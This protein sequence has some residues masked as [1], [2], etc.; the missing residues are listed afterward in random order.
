MMDDGLFDRFPMQEIYGLHNYPG[1][2][3]G[4]FAIRSGAMMAATDL[5][6]ITVEGK[7]G[8]AAKPQDCIDPLPIAAQII[9]GAQTLVSRRADPLDEVV[10]SLT[11]VH[12]GSAD[13]VIPSTLTLRG[14]VRTLSKAR[15]DA[16]EHALGLLVENTARAHGARA[17]LD[18][19]RSYP[20]LINH[21]AQTAFA[22]SMAAES[23]GADNVHVGAPPMMGG[24]DFAFYLEE[25]PGAFIF[26]GNGSSAGLH[27][28]AYD[29][30]D[31]LIPY[32]VSYWVQL[33][34]TRLG[35]LAG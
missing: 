33:A 1:L 14:T 31:G 32:G 3:V 24:E 25:V 22:A 20:V 2:P 4:Q 12:A 27:H 13:N 18:Y 9:L 19:K 5:L 35:Q 11:Q 8:H 15:Q 30:D 6:G 21:D 23:A 17:T 7:G 28:P 34:Q 10:V 29:F 16:V 26:A